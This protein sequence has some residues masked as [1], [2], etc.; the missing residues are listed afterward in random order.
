MHT[1]NSHNSDEYYST[2]SPNGRIIARAISDE[3]IG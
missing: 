3:I 2:F 1:I